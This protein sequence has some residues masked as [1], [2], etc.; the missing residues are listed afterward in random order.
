MPIYE[1]K[2]GKCGEVAEILLKRSDEKV[3]CPACGSKRLEKLM[4]TFSAQSSGTP[5]CAGSV[6]G[7]S[8]QT[9]ATGA[10]PMSRRM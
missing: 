10:C 5:E 6:P 1:Y 4:S 3:A 8:S 2:C 7:C 9:C